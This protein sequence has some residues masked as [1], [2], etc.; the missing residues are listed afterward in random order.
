MSAAPGVAA[1]TGM[2]SARE[3]GGVFTSSVMAGIADV[4]MLIYRRISVEMVERRLAPYR[5]WSVVAVMRIETIVHMS[6]ESV[7]AVEPGA[8][9]DEDPTSKPIGPIV[10]IWRTVVGGIVEI[11][12][13]TNRRRA[14]ADGYLRR[15]TR[16]TAQH[17][18]SE[19]R[20]SK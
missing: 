2:A 15:C 5:Y 7:R 20:K 16:R 18:H 3:A 11:A 17:G 4:A 1:A 13:G 9:S 12:I 6:I 14:N 19:S 10:P 8:S